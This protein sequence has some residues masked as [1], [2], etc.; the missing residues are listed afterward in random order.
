MT[1]SWKSLLFFLSLYSL[2]IYLLKTE[3]VTLN[4]EYELCILPWWPDLF[5]HFMCLFHSVTKIINI[6]KLFLYSLLLFW[7]RSIKK[8]HDYLWRFPEG[9]PDPGS[10]VQSLG[11]TFARAHGTHG[12]LWRLPRLD[13]DPCDIDHISISTVASGWLC[14]LHLILPESLSHI[15]ISRSNPKW[16]SLLIAQT[17]DITQ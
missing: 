6:K 8:K 1:Y 16:Q 15:H 17:D 13:R 7:T 11:D 12:V 10:A 3:D 9:P 4:I 2:W 14:T 5:S